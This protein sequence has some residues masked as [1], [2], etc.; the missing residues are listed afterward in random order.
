M[1]SQ[2][3]SINDSDAA[4]RHATYGSWCAERMGESDSGR[5]V[6]RIFPPGAHG[7]FHAAEAT[8]AARASL[9]LSL[10][11]RSSLIG[12]GSSL[13]VWSGAADG[14]TPRSPRACC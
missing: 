11:R 9:L 4:L 1:V 12:V 7:R 8:L 14:G 6:I 13:S 10:L 3:Q 5:Q 2:N